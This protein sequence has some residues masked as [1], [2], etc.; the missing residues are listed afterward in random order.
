MQESL[1]KAQETYR[2]KCQI[3]NIRVNKETESDIIEWLRRGDVAPRIK[4]LIR[5]DI[6]KSPAK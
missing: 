5:D 2:Q 4:K 1:K 6:N 3:I